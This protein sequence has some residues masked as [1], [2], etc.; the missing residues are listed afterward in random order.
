MLVDDVDVTSPYRTN[1]S[2]IS[3]SCSSVISD[4]NSRASTNASGRQSRSRPRYPHP[5]HHRL[6]STH[7]VPHKEGD[8]EEEGEEVS[9]GTMRGLP[10]SR[11]S[12]GV[13]T[14]VPLADLQ[15]QGQGR[16]HRG[17]GVDRGVQGKAKR[18][19]G[20]RGE[21]DG[22]NGIDND[23]VMSTAVTAFLRFLPIFE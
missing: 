12:Q 17:Q 1:A 19:R 4:V 8:E 11:S 18:E 16:T 2:V 7:P 5:H 21:D 9:F 23:D 13:A 22:H 14:V 3:S 6:Q 10:G 20:D 15:G